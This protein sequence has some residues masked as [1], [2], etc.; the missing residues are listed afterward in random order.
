[1]TLLIDVRTSEEYAEKHIEG[2]VNI[3][4]TAIESGS[5]GILESLEKDSPV[6]LYCRSGGRAGYA[7][8]LLQK[9]GFTNVTNLGGMED[10]IVT[11]H[12]R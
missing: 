4:V 8:A 3:P 5:R 1:M 11:P 10:V 2:A 6:L 12:S 7:L 9:E